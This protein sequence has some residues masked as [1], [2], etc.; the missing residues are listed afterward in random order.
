MKEIYEL[1]LKF[2]EKYPKTIAWRIKQ[3]CK[4]AA[5]HLNPDEEVNYV[6]VCQK[7]SSS[8]E[9]FRTFVVVITNKRVLIAQKRLFFGYLFITVTP[10]LYN[11]L[12]VMAGLIWGKIHIDTVKEGIE[13]S[14]IDKKALP[15]IETVI[16]QFMIEAKKE[17]E[18][19]C[20][21]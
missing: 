16:T 5:V 9:I 2:K 6:F 12:T 17:L 3:H 11:D 10:D 1:A 4:I 21:K 20:D 15:E 13:L 8:L 7:N 18:G 14:N 19:G